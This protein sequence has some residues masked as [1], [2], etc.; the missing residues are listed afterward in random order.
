MPKFN[1]KDK[2]NL[3]FNRNIQRKNIFECWNLIE[4]SQGKKNWMGKFVWKISKVY[5][6]TYPVC[7]YWNLNSQFWTANKVRFFV[8]V[9]IGISALASD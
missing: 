1:G 2:I 5:K 6:N 4:L 3:P 9:K 8:G 7:F